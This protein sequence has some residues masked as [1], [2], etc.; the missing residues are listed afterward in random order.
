VTDRVGTRQGERAYRHRV[1]AVGYAAVAHLTGRASMDRLRAETLAT[2]RGR[3]LLV[4]AGQ[5][6]DLPHLPPAVTEVVAVE[7]DPTMRRLGRAR[8]ARS[9]V[10]AVYIGAAA[11]R[12]PLADASVDTAAAALVLCSVRDPYRAAAELRRVLRP[13]GLLLVLEHVRGPSGSRTGRWQDRIDPLWWRLFGG[14]H[15]DRPTRA[16]LD[17]AGF[18]TSDVRDRHLARLVPLLDPAVQGVARPAG[19]TSPG[20]RPRPPRPAGGR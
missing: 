13:D 1:F 5:G 14:C 10:P 18:D 8:L 2:A 15:L 7:P 19:R 9:R 12:L 4:G 3:L 20:G 17:A 6:H 16:V 11:E